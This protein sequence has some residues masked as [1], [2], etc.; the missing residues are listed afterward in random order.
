MSLVCGALGVDLGLL[1]EGCV[2]PHKVTY[3]PRLV[4]GV[5][6]ERVGVTPNPAHVDGLTQHRQIGEAQLAV[7]YVL[8]EHLGEPW[9]ISHVWIFGLGN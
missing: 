8:A 7:E 2:V 4:L 1:E 3:P 5:E 9:Q 6:V